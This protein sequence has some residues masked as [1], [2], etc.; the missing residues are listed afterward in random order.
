MRPYLAR[1]A[2]TGRAG[3]AAI[4]VAQEFAPVFTATKKQ[5]GNDGVV[6]LRG[7]PAAGDLLLLLRLGRRFRAGVRQG[8]RLLPVSD[9]D[10]GQR[11]RVGQT[12]GGQGRDRVHR[13]VQR[14]R[15]LHRSGRAAGD[16]RPARPGRDP[17]VRRT[18]VVDPAAAADRARPRRR[19]LVGAV[20]APGR[21]L[22]HPGVRRTA[23]GPRVLRGP[24]R[25]QPRHRPPGTDRADLQTRPTPRRQG[26]QASTRPRSSPTAPRSTS[27]PSTGT[28]AS[29]SI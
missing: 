4:G 20:D 25:R 18:L 21:D 14:V 5:R 26:R 10:L 7:V 17:G 27:T 16:L 24:G 9:E 22:A 8:L 6:L 13:A 12:A 3:V 2:A 1:Q 15:H 29:N 11:P 23:A 19:L 28:P